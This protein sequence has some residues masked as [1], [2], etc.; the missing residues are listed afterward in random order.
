MMDPMDQKRTEFLKL[1]AIECIV[2]DNVD[3]ALYWTRIL[4]TWLD[5][6]RSFEKIVEEE[7][8]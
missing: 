7:I 1:K 4:K 3:E 6:V 2:H 5:A 8:R